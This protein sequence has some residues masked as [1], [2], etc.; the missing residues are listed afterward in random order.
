VFLAFAPLGHGM[1]TGAARRSSDYGCRRATG[2]NAG[3]GAAGLGGAAR[4]GSAYHA[5]AEARAA[6]LP[7]PTVRNLEL[8]AN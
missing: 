1:K 8:A 4:H 7:N 6:N 2:K 5:Q 3:T